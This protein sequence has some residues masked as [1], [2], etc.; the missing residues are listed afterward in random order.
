MKLSVDRLEA[1]PTRHA[2]EAEP[3]WWNERMIEGLEAGYDLDG[4]LRF[5]LD[6][7]RIGTEVF[8]E[9]DFEGKIEVDC[10][11][12]LRRYRHPLA[13]RFRLV[14][15]AAG[16]REP[17]DPEGARA[18]A[19]DGVA[20]GDEVELGWYRGPEITLDAFF[21]ELVSLALPLQPLCREDCAGLCPRCGAEL[22]EID[23]GCE[24]QKPTS[25][26]AVLA[27]LRDQESGGST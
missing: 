3:A 2:F 1:T 17:A 24:E 23:C 13:E 16:D 18:L 10:G 12:C 15:E 25:P 9:G 27:A 22:G 5:R 20:L 4:P 19:R 14:L 26:F 11:R 21:S 6:A 7:H 8:L